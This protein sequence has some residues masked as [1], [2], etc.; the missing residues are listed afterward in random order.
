M[1]YRR[2]VSRKLWEK[3]S[4]GAP[5]NPRKSGTLDQVACCERAN[6]VS[7]SGGQILKMQMLQSS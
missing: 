4:K 1:R 6:I 7:L 3:K 2:L 5:R